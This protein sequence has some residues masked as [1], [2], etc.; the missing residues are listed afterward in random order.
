MAMTLDVFANAQLTKLLRHLPHT[1]RKYSTFRTP[2]SPT[3]DMHGRR[4]NPS[5]IGQDKHPHYPI[6]LMSFQN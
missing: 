3:V 1:A 2:I 6:L 4:E 5:I